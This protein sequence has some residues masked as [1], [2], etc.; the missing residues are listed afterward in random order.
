LFKSRRG[1]DEKEQLLIDKLQTLLTKHTISSFSLS[2]AD[3]Q[4]VELMKNRKKLGLG[5]LSSIAFA[6]RT[7]QVFL[8]DDQKARKF[9]K[10][11][12]GNDRVQTTPHLYGWLL[13]NQ[14]LNESD[15]T[16]IL[17]EHNLNNRPL[18]P[19]F[20]EVH[21]ECLRIKLMLH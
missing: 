18:E 5:E 4:E 20:K 16:Y 14:H 7:S 10:K 8:T 21:Q 13:F 17:N 6:K 11:I 3:L 1:I 19:Y 9:A 2:I 12:L 15:L